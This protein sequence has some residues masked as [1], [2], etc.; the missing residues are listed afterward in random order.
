M[1]KDKTTERKVQEDW[2]PKPGQVGYRK[3]G[4]T[5]LKISEVG[6]GGH[7]WAYKQVPDGKGG[8]RKVTIDEATRMIE[9][10]IE[11]AETCGMQFFI[12]W[13]N[14]LLGEIALQTDSDRAP[15]YLEKSIAVLSEIKAKNERAFTLAAYGRFYKRQ[16]EEEKARQYLTEALG[17]FERLKTP[18]EADKVKAEL[19]TIK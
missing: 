15:I 17:T 14:R 13:G 2:A 5:G 3:L 8:Y 10:A 9:S 1:A 19:A 4:K 7:S 16:G 6:F 11:L 18:S 12:G